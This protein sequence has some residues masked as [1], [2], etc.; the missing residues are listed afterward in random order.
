ML[1][2]DELGNPRLST[3][4]FGRWGLEKWR[5][6]RDGMEIVGRIE[7]KKVAWNWLSLYLEILWEAHSWPCIAQK[8]RM[9]LV[10]KLLIIVENLALYWAD[11]KMGIG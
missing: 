2:V 6:E 9:F 5:M 4:V 3:I 8:E 11:V 1:I 7:S 10:L